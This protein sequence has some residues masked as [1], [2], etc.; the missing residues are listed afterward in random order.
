MAYYHNIVVCDSGFGGLDITRLLLDALYRHG[1]SEPERGISITYFNAWPHE[2]YGYN[3]LSSFSDKQLIFSRVLDGIGAFKP[4]LCIFAC[5][6][7]SVLYHGS[8]AYMTLPYQ[9]EDVLFSAADDL[10]AKLSVK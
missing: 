4:D 6:T 10:A 9:V 2:R 7:L 5:N 1:V 3:H 8:K